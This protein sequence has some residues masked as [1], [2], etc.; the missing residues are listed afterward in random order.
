ML[1]ITTIRKNMKQTFQQIWP[2]NQL[3]ILL[4]ASSVLLITLKY[5]SPLLVPFLISSAIAIILSPLFKYLESKH[6]PRIVSLFL[7]STLSAIP[8]IALAGYIGTEVQDFAL[9]FQVMKE[10]FNAAIN[11]FSQYLMKY[12]IPV[13][14]DKLRS[15]AQQANIGGLIQNLATQTGNQFSNLFLIFFTAAFML[16]ESTFLYNKLQKIMA[17]KGKDSEAL[18][19]IVK[20]I[21]SY[22]LIKVKTSLLTGG[23]VLLILWFYDIDYPF[24]WATLA[25][26]FNFVPVIGSIFAAIPAIITAFLGG[27]MVLAGWVSLWYVFIN[28]V[29]GNILEPRIMGKGLGLSSLVVLL[30]MTFWGWIFGPTGM[31]LSVP[32]TMCLQ[33][34]FSQFEDTEWVA[35]ALTDYEKEK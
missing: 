32:L 30:S 9:N 22:F 4:S 25:F 33:F 14:P 31:I 17:D 23:L 1:A 20:K 5:A 29:V 10:Q 15:M 35:F 21:K 19:E 24:L 2:V 7:V 16:M 6:I 3:F 34:L 18:M 27:G 12:G 13:G 28:T 11:S 8:M 26:S